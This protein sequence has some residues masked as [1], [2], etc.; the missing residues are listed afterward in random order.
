MVDLQVFPF[1]VFTALPPV[2][3]PDTERP[4]GVGRAFADQ[5]GVALDAAGLV[6]QGRR[7]RP[8]AIVEHRVVQRPQDPRVRVLVAHVNSSQHQNLRTTGLSD[9]DPPRLS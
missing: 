9:P 1:H 5:Q 7:R 4:D 8:A 3:E 6:N 2:V